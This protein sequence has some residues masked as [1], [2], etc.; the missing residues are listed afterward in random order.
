[1]GSHA[2]GAPVCRLV[3]EKV[4]LDDRSV[5]AG[6]ASPILQVDGAGMSTPGKVLYTFV[7]DY[8]E[9][10]IGY[11]LEELFPDKSAKLV[12]CV[13]PN[14]VKSADQHCIVALKRI[15]R[16]VT[17]PDMDPEQVQVFRELTMK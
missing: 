4:G 5:D 3:I 6:Q 9:D 12:S 2:A 15:A 14:P 1:M 10:D 16:D 17:W 11:A 7:S 13:A 8:H